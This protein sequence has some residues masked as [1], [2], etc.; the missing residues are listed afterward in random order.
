MKK[1]LLKPLAVTALFCLG[2]LTATAQTVYGLTT[3]SWMD[4]NDDFYSGIQTASVDLATLNLEA[5][6]ELTLGGERLADYTTQA[7]AGVGKKFYAVLAKNDNDLSRN[8]IS[9]CTVNFETGVVTNISSSAYGND[10]ARQPGYG[11]RSMAYDESTSTLYGIE[12]SFDEELGTTVTVLYSIDQE[13]GALTKLASYTDEYIGIAAKDGKLYL[14][15]MTT[16]WEGKAPNLTM[17]TTFSLYT[18]EADY[19]VAET[20]LFEAE[21]VSGLSYNP[22]NTLSFGA[23]GTLYMQVNMKTYAIDL[24]AKTVTLKGELSKQLFGLS[25]TK[26]TEGGVAGGGDEP[27]T[28]VTRMLVRST[29]YGDAMG[30][31]T[32]DMNKTEYYYKSDN[33][34]SREVELGRGYDELASIYSVMNLV[35]Y[36]YDDNNLLTGTEQWQT[37]LYDFGDFAYALRSTKNYEY[38]ENGRLVTEPDG[39]Y[40][41]KHEYDESGN[42][43]KTTKS[44]TSGV[45][46]VLEYSDFAGKNKPRSIVSTSP[47]H[48]EW[49][50]Y[51]YTA[52][53]TYDANGNKTEELQTRDGSN[54]QRETWTYDE[55]YHFLLT[56]Y[57]KSQFD[58]EGNETPTIKIVY[59]MVDGNPNKVMRND[60]TYN[61]GWS[62]KPTYYIDEY[63]DFSGMSEM[64]AIKDLKAEPVEGELN[65]VKLSF[66]APM[67][68]NFGCKFNIYRKGEPILTNGVVGEDLTQEMDEETGTVTLSYVDS[69]L[70]NGDYEYFVQ[71]VM[72]VYT[73]DL[74]GDE[75]GD[76]TVAYNISNIAEITLALDLPAVTN[77]TQG[78]IR[79]DE[80]D[81]TLV[82]IEWTNPDYPEE[83][84]F[85]S[86]NLHFVNYQLADSTTTNPDA[87]SLEGSF[88]RNSSVF[89]L[90]RYK[91]GKAISD[92]LDVN[93]LATGIES[94]A[95]KS[96]ATISFNGREVVLSENA[97]I[98]VY[99]AAGRQELRAADTDSVSLERLTPGVYVVCVTKDGVTTA[100]K[101]VVR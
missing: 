80:N 77:L 83:Y 51:F 56:Q 55:T 59:S 5:A 54:L 7:A 88:Y 41:L 4:E 73:D 69:A 28:P 72:T 93:L 20:P 23:D 11:I 3:N 13:N 94:V 92:T 18:A 66:T 14:P 32:G 63:V 45:V 16:T 26:P 50:G 61:D 42:I 40:T 48:P 10:D 62:G 60:S 33:K 37:G 84:G 86:N 52:T 30:E 34:L 2:A 78:S 29:R 58:S 57:L 46:Q 82:K 90:T 39:Y 38:D 76:E 81:N 27:E 44:N 53:V 67:A 36:N 22:N 89:V 95:T 97:D 85:I 79:K 19:T 68:A 25:F 9:L 1:T 70:Y 12:Q 47:D 35:K 96:G 21:G 101:V 15:K 43:V 49:T 8:D 65:T 98:A 74:Y 71:P 64:V 87:T 91:Y 100:H 75:T 31:S 6:A 24:D 17:K 99:S